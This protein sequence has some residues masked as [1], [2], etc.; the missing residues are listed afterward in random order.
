MSG[1]EPRD[2]AVVDIIDDKMIYMGGSKWGFYS[3][4][5]VLEIDLLKKE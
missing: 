1:I 2:R 5:E 3:Y 4:L